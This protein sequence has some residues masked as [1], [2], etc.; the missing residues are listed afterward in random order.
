MRRGDAFSLPRPR[1]NRTLKHGDS[2]GR[3]EKKRQGSPV[4]RVVMGSLVAC[5]FV[6]IVIGGRSLVH[7]VNEWTEIQQITIV[8]LDRLSRE[9]VMTKMNLRQH[10]SLW[11]IDI[12]LLVD[13]VE[14]H[15]WIRSIAV[16]RVFP[17]SLAVQVEERQPAAVLAASKKGY[18]LDMEGYLLPSETAKANEA[19]PV[20]AGMA[21]KFFHEHID[22]SHRRAKQGIHL[23]S[24][25]SEHFSGRPR[26]NMAHSHTTTI[27][28]P[29]IRVQ[30]G[31]EAEQQW[32]RFLVLYP[33][34]QE[35]IARQS[36]EVDLRFSQKVI[37]RKR[38]L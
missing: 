32:K 18:F 10:S 16:D 22:E 5:L 3:K 15:P 29:R 13:Q 9:E 35:V 34:V 27:D 4:R 28:L 33:S 38:T 31:Q 6:A 19:L 12:D 25:L 8:G 37:L 17:H 20:L 21:P 2:V 30:F 1:N 24:L 14:A 36:Q 7:S 23:A 26:V 11:S